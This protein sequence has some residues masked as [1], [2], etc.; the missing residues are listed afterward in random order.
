MVLTTLGLLGALGLPG[1]CVSGAPGNASSLTS[2]ADP[3][4]RKLEQLGNDPMFSVL[5]PDA[6]A[7]GPVVATP[8]THRPTDLDGGAD[9]APSVSAQVLSSQPLA[10]VFTF[11]G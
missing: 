5:P 10:A 11:Y 1:G 6:K 2:N 8:A 4:N 3:G 9:D 7:D